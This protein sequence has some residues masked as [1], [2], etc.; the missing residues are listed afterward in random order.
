MLALSVR[1]Q[2]I[3]LA[4]GALSLT[5]AA[6][7]PVYTVGGASPDFPSLP[8]AVAA[9]PPGSILRVLPGVHEGFTTGKPL[10][11][12][13]EFD[14]LS[15]TIQAPAGSA[16]AISIVGLPA[17]DEF[18]LLGRDAPVQAGAVGGIR[19][20]NCGGPVVLERIYVVAG[21]GAVGIEVE[22]AAVVHLRRSV[23]AGI[24]GLLAQDTTLM[25]S[26]C[27]VV[28]TGGPGSAIDHARFEATRT[29]FTGWQQP[30]LRL[31]HCVARMTSN[32]QSA[33]TVAGA[34]VPV[35]AIEA[36]D[37]QLQMDTATLGLLPANGAPGL[38]LV[39]GS[40]LAEEVPMLTTSLATPGQLATAT[41]TSAAPRLGVMVLGDLMPAPTLLELGSFFVD[42][43]TAPIVL[44]IG[45]CD[46][47]GL[48]ASGTVPTAAAL[49]G[50]IWCVQG[51]V[52]RIGALPLFS[53]PGLLIAL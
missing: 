19:I 22:N 53:G 10:R 4:V 40:L 43:G 50:H 2:A 16:H 36:I 1:R 24:S 11:V 51:A 17:G 38:E 52:E 27:V 8:A 34:S 41:M 31:S 25:V 30:G 13:L 32:G 42:V 26:E 47:N 14:A 29:Y 33:V 23:F 5:L 3:T 45:V 18:V 12:L 15:G 6:Q 39:G 21:G 46:A 44:A 7:R 37:C 35:A 20:A 48:G 28:G 9:V 49:Y